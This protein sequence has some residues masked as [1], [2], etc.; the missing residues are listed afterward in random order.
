MFGCWTCVQTEVVRL[1]LADLRRFAAN[2][3]LDLSDGGDT[4][5]GH[6]QLRGDA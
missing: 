3:F 5:S 6:V 2:P 4:V 1:C